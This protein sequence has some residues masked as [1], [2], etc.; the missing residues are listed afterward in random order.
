MTLLELLQLLK[1]YLALVIALPVVFAI[2]MAIVAYGFMSNNYTAET[3]LYVLTDT[4]TEVSSTYSTSQYIT[5]DVATLITSS[6]VAED[7]AAALGFE[8]LN[9]YTISV[10]SSTSNRVITVS[11]RGKDARNVARVANEIAI[12]VD[13]LAQEIM[14][15]NSINVISEASVPTSPSGPN[16][17]M[18][19]AIA[20]VVG[21]FLAIVIVVLIDMTNTK[22]RSSDD[23]E[24][25]LGVPVIARIPYMKGGK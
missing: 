14:N 6:R 21:L 20:F 23:I 1:K 17:P 4:D 18:Y 19:I 12:S 22:V 16:R 5:N 2:V 10:S 11:V 24:E 3:E 15:I 13:S 25:L 8:N 7:T 9:A